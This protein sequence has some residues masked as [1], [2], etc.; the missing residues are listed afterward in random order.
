VEIGGAFR[1]P[2]VM[3]AA[4]CKLREFRSDNGKYFKYGKFANYL[5]ETNVLQTFS[6]GYEHEMNGL[7]EASNR[8]LLERMRCLMFENE[9]PSSWWPYAMVT[10]A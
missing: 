7:A 4:N 1:I 9:V 3:A 5:R 6:V 10:A 8:I 2:D